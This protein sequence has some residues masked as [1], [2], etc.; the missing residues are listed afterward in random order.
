M[1]YKKMRDDRCTNRTVSK[2]E[3]VLEYIRKQRTE[4]IMST[5]WIEEGCPHKFCNTRQGQI[6]S[7]SGKKMDRDRN[8]PHGLTHVWWRRRRRRRR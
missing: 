4:E 3:P 2:I 8:G 7:T 6:Y 5:E 1:K